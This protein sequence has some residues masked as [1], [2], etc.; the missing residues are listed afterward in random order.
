MAPQYP[1]PAQYAGSPYSAGQQAPQRI[2][3]SGWW[4][5]VG[6]LLIVGG[7]V[8]GIVLGVLG[9]VG[10]SGKV[11]DLQRVPVPGSGAVQL[12]ETGGYTVNFEYPGASEH[13]FPGRIT[14]SITDP[15]GAAVP[16]QDYSAN[17]TYTF[18]KHEGRAAFSFTAN[19]PG[20]YRVT[21]TGGPATAA[22]G[23]GF[24]TS[25]A[26]SLVGAFALGFGG[27]VLGVIALIV[28]GVKR[29]RSKRRS[30]APA[31]WTGGYP[32]GPQQYGPPQSGQ[33]Q[34]GPQQYG[35]PQYG[36][37]QSGPREY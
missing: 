24:G 17:V 16:L 31:G 10:M 30:T 1:E 8:G 2:T 34:S 35:P 26:G 18:G 13:G 36:P 25:L 33:P 9:F 21:T 20:T 28:V 3:P 14:T 37:P 27:L 22:I 12:T 11:D 29:G 6:A 15:S 4:F 19:T 7:L 32:Q 23:R 5:V